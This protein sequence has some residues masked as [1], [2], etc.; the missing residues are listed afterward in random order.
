M[1]KILSK[2]DQIKLDL[3]Q[4]ASQYINPKD[5]T[6]KIKKT[7]KHITEIDL[8]ISDLLNKGMILVSRGV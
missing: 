3:A 6:S 8:K 4:K 5:V 1:N 2:K 7:E